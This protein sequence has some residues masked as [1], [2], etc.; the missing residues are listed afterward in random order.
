MAISLRNRCPVATWAQLIDA[1][2]E[3]NTM[4]GVTNQRLNKADKLQACVSDHVYVDATVTSN[5]GQIIYHSHCFMGPWMRIGTQSGHL[6][7]SA[8]QERVALAAKVAAQAVF[9]DAVGAPAIAA[10]QILL[11]ARTAEWDAVKFDI[12]KDYTDVYPDWNYETGVKFA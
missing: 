5:E 2:S 1:A 3:I 8:A 10:A 9:D 11:D 7:Y 4:S 12:T 6:L